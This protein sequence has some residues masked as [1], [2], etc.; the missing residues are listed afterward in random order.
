MPLYCIGSQLPRV[1]D[2]HFE[3]DVIADLLFGED[4]AD[5]G[6]TT[7]RKTSNKR[8]RHLFEHLTNTP[9]RLIETRRLLETRRLFEHLTNTPRRLFVSCTK[10]Q[11]L[12]PVSEHVCDLS[13]CLSVCLRVF[14]SISQGAE[15]CNE[16]DCDL[17]VCQ[18]GK[19]RLIYR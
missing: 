19:L 11:I 6:D 16:H 13:V 9:R 8:P 17:S 12:V 3:H 5:Q 14:V 10:W 7:Y 2:V 18:S 15:Y 1:Q 4:D